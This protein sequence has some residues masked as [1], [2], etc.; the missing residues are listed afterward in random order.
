MNNKIN[1]AEFIQAF[2]K[3]ISL[4]HALFKSDK[5]KSN[6]GYRSTMRF[7][8]LY[9][10]KKLGLKTLAE[11]AEFFHLKKNTLSEMISRME[12]DKLLLRQI[13][14]QDRRQ[15]IFQL[16]PRA[17]ELL[18]KMC[19]EFEQKIETLFCGLKAEEQKEFQKTI[20]SLANT[21]NAFRCQD[22]VIND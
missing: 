2:L 13:S 14:R 16:T 20:H 22:E 21:L 10:I 3:I 17:E 5:Q 8:L 1:S 7:F 9:A 18:Q 11:L 4:I 6:H 12:N 15:F 19:S